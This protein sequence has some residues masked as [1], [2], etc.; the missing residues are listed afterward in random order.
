MLHSQI[1]CTLLALIYQ[2]LTWFNS[3]IYHVCLPTFWL[4]PCPRDLPLGFLD[5]VYWIS[6]FEFGSDQR[7]FWDYPT[8]LFFS[9]PQHRTPLFASLSPPVDCAEPVVLNNKDR[10]YPYCCAGVSNLW[11]AGCMWPPRWYF[12]MPMIA[13][14]M[15]CHPSKTELQ[16]DEA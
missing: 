6:G 12:L 4:P 11:P 9:P 1:V 15:I 13:I 14:A 16:H 2:D 3:W 7:G 10:G 5:T 8:C